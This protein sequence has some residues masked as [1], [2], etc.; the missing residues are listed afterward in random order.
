[1]TAFLAPIF[2]AMGMVADVTGVPGLGLAATVLQGIK[3]NC[4]KVV[5]HKV[6]SHLT[7]ERIN[8][9]RLCSPGRMP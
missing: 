7:E 2:Q 8:K 6:R 5:S 3:D 4:D 9:D 1:M